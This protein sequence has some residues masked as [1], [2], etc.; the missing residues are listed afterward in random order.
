MIRAF[1]TVACV[2]A[3]TACLAAGVTIPISAVYGT[4]AACYRFINGG[5]VAVDEILPGEPDDADLMLLDETGIQSLESGCEPLSVAGDT[6][7]MAC[8][9]EGDDENVTATLS[10]V[11]PG[12]LTLTMGPSRYWTGEY[13]LKACR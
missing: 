2:I 5:S 13:H 4:P 10:D 9:V 3:S 1:M 8:S 12:S 6:I 7:E 11:T